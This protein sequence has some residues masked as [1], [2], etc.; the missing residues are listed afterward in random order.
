MQRLDTELT[1]LFSAWKHGRLGTAAPPGR[2]GRER[3]RGRGRERELGGA[4]TLPPAR[5]TT[6]RKLL[7][8]DEREATGGGNGLVCFLVYTTCIIH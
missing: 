4:L 5:P 3:K 7:K 6:P 8:R 2:E 1:F